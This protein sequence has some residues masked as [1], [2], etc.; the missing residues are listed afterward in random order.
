MT[1]VDEPY[2]VQIRCI[3]GAVLIG[4]FPTRDQAVA[5]SGG[6]GSL[7]PLFPPTAS[8]A[9]LQAASSLS[10]AWDMLMPADQQE[11]LVDLS[12]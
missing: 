2:I 11:P 9:M 10:K 12:E 8:A 7:I 3:A 4:P 6:L 1:A 5:W